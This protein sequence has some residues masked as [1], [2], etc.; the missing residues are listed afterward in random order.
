M[1]AP[2]DP[3]VLAERARVVEAGYAL[4]D[5]VSFSLAGTAIGLLGDWSPLFRVLGRR[6]ELAQGLLLVRGR[7]A[8]RAVARGF[9]GLAEAA[10]QLP[11]R[12]TAF[13]YL[14]GSAV[15]AG[16]RP[17]ERGVRR[18]LEEL[19]LTW[20]L[21]RRVETLRLLERR[22]LL[23]ANACLGDPGPDVL[24]IEQ[25]FFGLDP[26]ECETIVGLVRRAAAGR[27]LLVSTAR[28]GVGPEREFLSS[29]EAVYRLSAAGANPVDLRREGRA[30][31]YLVVAPERGQELLTALLQAGTLAKALSSG[32][33]AEPTRLVVTLEPDRDTRVIVET[34]VRLGIAIF[35]LA[36]LDSGAF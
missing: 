23:I 3:L 20:L 11:A 22:A 28:A 21:S 24:A 7:A 10:P 14:V 27:C 13:E 4:W 2:A 25:P 12:L 6:A 16:M 19:G 15:L 31:R 26:T 29:L 18:R 1:E 9:V 36:P 32:S 17:G 8:D 35:E 34:A 5:G 30:S 33:E